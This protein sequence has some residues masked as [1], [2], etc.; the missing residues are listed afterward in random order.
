MK[1]NEALHSREAGEAPWRPQA[2]LE[3]RGPEAQPCVQEHGDGVRGLGTPPSQAEPAEAS[4]SHAPEP[5]D[6]GRHWTAAII[7]IPPS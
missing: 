2:V 7:P 3:D 1:G 4:V 6:A 5:P